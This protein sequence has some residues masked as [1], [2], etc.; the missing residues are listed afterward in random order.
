MNS[1]GSMTF[2]R[3]MPA[4]RAVPKPSKDPLP[5]PKNDL[6]ITAMSVVEELPSEP[7][8]ALSEVPDVSE[9]PKAA[10]P[11]PPQPAKTRQVASEPLP[12]AEPEP[13][14][15]A[16]TR[17]VES[18]PP[19]VAEPEASSSV[20]THLIELIIDSLPH[21]QLIETIP[22]SVESLG[23]KVFTA[24]VHPLNL[25]GTGNTLGDALIIVKEQIEIQYE[26]LSKASELEADERKYL[27]YLQSHIK[28]SSSGESRP[29]KKSLWR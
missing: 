18:E 17:Q 2:A 9:P 6:D 8:A 11:E 14:L 12:A 7:M 5:A 1:A 23:D 20:E 3:S 24:T 16:E 25:V 10:D 4:Q 15:P 22:V 13:E 27:K 28:D 26:Q 29:Q 19:V 21:Q